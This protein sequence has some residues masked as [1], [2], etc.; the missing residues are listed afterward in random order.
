MLWDQAGPQAVLKVGWTSGRPLAVLCCPGRS[1]ARLSGG[2]GPWLYLQLGGAADSS[3]V[4]WG[5]CPGSQVRFSCRL[6]SAIAQG[7]RLGPLPGEATGSVEQ[8][9]EPWDGA[10][11]GESWAVLHGSGGIIG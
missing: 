4:S 7:H 10:G 8:S 9:A 11:A 2:R 6:C 3:V 5:R 1:L